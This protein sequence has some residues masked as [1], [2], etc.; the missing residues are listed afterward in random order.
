MIHVPRFSFPAT[1]DNECSKTL[2]E[3]LSSRRHFS[4]WVE[5]FYI[6]KLGPSNLS[7]TQPPCGLRTDSA[8]SQC[9]VVVAK[10]R[11]AL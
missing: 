10:H 11:R 1:W 3:C 9:W 4:N 8:S 5:M 6:L 7:E 2:S